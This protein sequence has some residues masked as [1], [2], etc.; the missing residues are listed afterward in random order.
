MSRG[1]D[2][3][4]GTPVRRAGVDVVTVATA[5]HWFDPEVALPAVHEGLRPGSRLAVL[6]NTRDEARL[7]PGGSGWTGTRC[8]QAGDPGWEVS[9][10]WSCYQRLRSAFTTKN[11]REGKT[12][13]LGVLE[14]FHTCPIPEITPAG[15]NPAQLAETVPCLLHHRPS[16]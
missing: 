8:G 2:P 13:A 1:P 4:R 3:R 9:L 14:S 16:Q 12:I 6:L 11:L 7:G 15:P 5:F 10:A